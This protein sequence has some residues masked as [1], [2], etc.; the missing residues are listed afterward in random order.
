MEFLT[1]TNNATGARRYFVDGRRVSR[2]RFDAAKMWKRLD[3][4]QT[5][6]RGGMV[7]QY[8]QGRDA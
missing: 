5:I 6:T 2:E 8:C 4:F 1:T 7:R 3:T